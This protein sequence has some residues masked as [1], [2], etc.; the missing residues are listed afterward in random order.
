M[1]CLLILLALA[2]LPLSGCQSA[3][4][5]DSG[6][7][8]GPPCGWRAVDAGICPHAGYRKPTVI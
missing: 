5:P 7:V 4:P 3:P 1:R 8:Y 2:V 6:V